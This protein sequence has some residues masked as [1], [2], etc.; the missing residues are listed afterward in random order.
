MPSLKMSS[1]QLYYVCGAAPKQMNP[2][3]GIVI[4]DVAVTNYRFRL[5]ILHVWD[6]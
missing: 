4:R 2:I 5:P 1:A 3:D 6:L